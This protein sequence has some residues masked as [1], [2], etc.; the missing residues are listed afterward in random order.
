[1]ALAISSSLNINDIVFDELFTHS[2][3]NTSQFDAMNTFAMMIGYI[4][5]FGAVFHSI[6]YVCSSMINIIIHMMI[7][8]YKFSKKIWNYAKNALNKRNLKQ[9]KIT[10]VTTVTENVVVAENTSETK[11]VS[12]NEQIKPTGVYKISGICSKESIKYYYDN[13]DAYKLTHPNLNRSQI[14]NEL[15]RSWKTE[16]QNK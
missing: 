7:V 16:Q 4:V 8:S 1:M 5:L 14:R 15:Y 2:S 12:S 6:M 3:M 9:K 10:P 13:K 11:I